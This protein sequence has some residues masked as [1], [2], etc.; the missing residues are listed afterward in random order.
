MSCLCS[1]APLGRRESRKHKGTAQTDVRTGFHPHKYIYSLHHYIQSL[2]LTGLRDEKA[3]F[4]NHR[5]RGGVLRPAG[6]SPTAGP[7]GWWRPTAGRLL[8]ANRLAVVTTNRPYQEDAPRYCQD[9]IRLQ[10]LPLMKGEPQLRLTYFCPQVWNTLGECK[11]PISEDGHTD[12]VSCVRF[13]PNLQNPLIV[14]GGWDKVVKVTPFPFLGQFLFFSCS[15][16]AFSSTC[17]RSLFIKPLDLHRWTG[18][19]SEC[20][21]LTGYGSTV[22]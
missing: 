11:S 18:V 2:F 22:A 13:S 19:I 20:L 1:A 3:D 14:S 10:V 9:S 16:G 4:S 5:F 21:Q 8:T 7:G 15:L 12:W 17:Q 6:A